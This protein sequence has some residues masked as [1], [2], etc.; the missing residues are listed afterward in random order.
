MLFG[1]AQMADGVA[2]ASIYRSALSVGVGK[3]LH[4][5]MEVPKDLLEK[6][7]KTDWLMAALVTLSALKFSVNLRPV[8]MVR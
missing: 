3:Y 7:F 5:Q 4:T 1:C 8:K 6:S 2:F